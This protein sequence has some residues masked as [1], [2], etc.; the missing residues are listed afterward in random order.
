MVFTVSLA[1]TVVMVIVFVGTTFVIS[2][3]RQLLQKAPDPND[4]SSGALSQVEFLPD[5]P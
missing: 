2:N 4:H 3:L 1:V 5:L